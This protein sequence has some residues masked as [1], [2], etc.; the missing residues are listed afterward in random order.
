MTIDLNHT[1]NDRTPYFYI[2]QH[3]RSQRMYAGCRYGKGCHPTELLTSTGYCTSSK[4]VNDIILSEGID[5][6]RIVDIILEED[7]QLPFG[8]SSIFEYETWFLREHNCSKSSKWLNLHNNSD[9]HFPFG[10]KEFKSLLLQK[11]GVD[12]ISKLESIKEKKRSTTMAHFNVAHPSQSAEIK[13]SCKSTN[14]DRYGVPYAMQSP[15]IKDKA[16]KSKLEKNNGS[17]PKHTPAQKELYKSTMLERYGVENAMFCNEFKTK[18]KETMAKTMS[19]PEWKA[20][21][22]RTQKEVQSRPEERERNSRNQKIAQNRPEVKAAKSLIGKGKRHV[23]NPETGERRR[24][25][26]IEY[27]LSN[28][29]VAGLGPRK[30]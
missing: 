4:L 15:A 10:T 9:Y 8:W 18:M 12:N 20:R 5:A 26:N 11:Y 17:F 19:D 22:S 3:I 1:H 30:I 27:Y 13:E 25:A 24:V 29:W 14:L 28:G 21:F 7:I 2:L 23:H 16:L 6:F